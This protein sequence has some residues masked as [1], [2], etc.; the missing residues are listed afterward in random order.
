[1]LIYKAS[2][3]HFSSSCQNRN[4]DISSEIRAKYVMQGYLCFF[5]IINGFEKSWVESL[6]DWKHRSQVSKSDFYILSL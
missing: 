5:E 3:D 1:M 6:R 4:F 2:P